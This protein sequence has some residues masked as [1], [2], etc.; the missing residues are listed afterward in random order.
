MPIMLMDTSFKILMVNEAY[1]SLTGLDKD[2][3]VGMNARD[4]KILEQS[5]EGLKKVLAEKKR[6]FGEIKDPVPDRYPYP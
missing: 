1:I 4:F 3:L 6:S 2:R 5:G